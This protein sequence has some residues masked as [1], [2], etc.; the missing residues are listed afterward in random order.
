MGISTI[1]R[2]GLRR[3]LSGFGV[4]HFATQ[5]PSDLEYDPQVHVVA[6][7]RDAATLF[8]D[9]VD[10]AVTDVM[11]EEADAGARLAVSWYTVPL[12][13]L[14]KLYSW[15]RVQLGGSGP[16]PEGMA[17]VAALRNRSYGAQHAARAA[18]V[19]AAAAQWQAANGYPPA[20]WTLVALARTTTATP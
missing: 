6:E 8:A 14:M 1:S 18:A 5:E 15:T 11:L 2:D 12:A 13:R 20:Y 4:R 9:H 16:I 3:W 7:W 19:R 10:N 17:P